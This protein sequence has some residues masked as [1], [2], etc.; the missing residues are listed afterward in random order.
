MIEG[1]GSVSPKT[2]G[3]YGSGSATLGQTQWELSREDSANVKD[4]REEITK[5]YIRTGDKGSFYLDQQ[6]YKDLTGSKGLGA[7]AAIS[8]VTLPSSESANVIVT[9]PTT[10]IKGGSCQIKDSSSF[11]KASRCIISQSLLSL[12][13]TAAVIVHIKRPPFFENGGNLHIRV[14]P[15]WPA[16][17]RIRDILVQIRTRG[18]LPLTNGSKFGSGTGTGSGSCYFRQWPSRRQLYKLF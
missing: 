18:S 7:A 17:L 1:S 12:I 13:T 9:G 16:V 3:Y 5:N 6:P 14:P 8:G 2:Y 10:S 4:H 11:V 15:I